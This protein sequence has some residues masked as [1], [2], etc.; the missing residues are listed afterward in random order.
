MT[1]HAG[2]P[3]V[4]PYL[5]IMRLLMY[6]FFMIMRSRTFQYGNDDSIAERI[7]IQC[8]LDAETSDEETSDEEDAENQ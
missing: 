3:G 1:P 5:S 2:H 4:V 7:R 6:H 8:M